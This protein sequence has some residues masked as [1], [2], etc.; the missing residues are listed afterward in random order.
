MTA[1]ARARRVVARLLG[2]WAWAAA[3]LGAAVSLLPIE[4]HPRPPAGAGSE[5]TADRATGVRVT[6][7]A[8]AGFPGLYWRAV[9][10]AWCGPAFGTPD[11]LHLPDPDPAAERFAAWHR[12]AGSPA[13]GWAAWRSYG[14]A[15]GSGP[16]GEWPTVWGGELAWRTV[17]LSLALPWLLGVPLLVSLARAVAAARGGW[18][19]PVPAGRWRR[20]ARPWAA[21][22]AA[23]GTAAVLFAGPRPVPTGGGTHV[24]F[25]PLRDP[26][27]DPHPRGLRLVV[28]RAPP[29]G[30]PALGLLLMDAGTTDRTLGGRRLGVRVESVRSDP[31]V[32]G[33]PVPTWSRTAVDLSLWYA[34]LPAAA[35]SGLTLWRTRAGG[36]SRTSPAASPGR[37]RPA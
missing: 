17:G 19:D 20:A 3:I 6:P 5:P 22:F 28:V 13:G 11:R 30:P 21:T 34:L 15:T 14:G 23:I 24:E 29:P 27:V 33:V 12:R 18:G 9:T 8:A 35:W 37:M 25:A 2:P 16:D 31:A 10:V 32:R 4:S 1:A 36:R 26:Y 7:A